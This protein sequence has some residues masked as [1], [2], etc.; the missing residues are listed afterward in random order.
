MKVALLSDLHIEVSEYTEGLP[1]ADFLVLAG[2]ICDG[3]K[4]NN[5]Y[6]NEFMERVKYKFGDNFVY[7][8]GNH[9]GYNGDTKSVEGNRG[10]KIQDNVCF[11]YATLWSGENSQ[12]AYTRISDKNNI[13]GFSFDWMLQ[14]H[15]LDLQ[16][17]EDSLNEFNKN[18]ITVVVTHHLPHIE[19]THPKWK[20]KE[21]LVT[22]KFLDINLAFYTDLDK[23]ISS[24]GPNYWFCGHTHDSLIKTIHNTNFFINPK[25]RK[26]ENERNFNPNLVVNID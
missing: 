3:K 23:L 1:D 12:Y 22:N 25:G 4:E 17:I 2:D 10:V 19:C 26:T 6:Y 5:K 14:Q 11:I 16:H 7:V 9:E 20:A 8:F 21:A 18:Y 24:N 13:K 15:K